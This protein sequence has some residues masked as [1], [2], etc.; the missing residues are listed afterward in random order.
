MILVSRPDHS[1]KVT[2]ETTIYTVFEDR[3]GSLCAL[4]NDVRPKFPGSIRTYRT[5]FV[6]S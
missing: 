2:L 4:T 1:H 5:M 3:V 6:S